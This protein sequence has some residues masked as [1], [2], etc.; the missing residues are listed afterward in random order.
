M[1]PQKTRGH[2]SS[3]FKVAIAA[4]AIAYSMAMLALWKN[5]QPDLSETGVLI[6]SVITP[7]LVYKGMRT[8]IKCF[9]GEDGEKEK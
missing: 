8:T 7:L 3:E 4:T 9:H 5:P 2:R 1:N 6:G